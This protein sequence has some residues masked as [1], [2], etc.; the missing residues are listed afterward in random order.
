MSETKRPLQA[1]LFRGVNQME[2]VM[3]GIKRITIREGYRDYV[4]GP[5]LIGCHILNWCVMRNVTHVRHLPMRNIFDDELSDSGYTNS[6]EML[7]DLQSYYPDM[8][9]DSPVTI[10]R[11]E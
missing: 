6:D 10:I 9:W 4:E 5:I 2:D 11:F 7:N 1:L 3:Y 8:G